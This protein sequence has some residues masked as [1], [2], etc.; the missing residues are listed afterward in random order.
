MTT[1]MRFPPVQGGAGAPTF[2]VGAPPAN[3]YARHN[4]ATIEGR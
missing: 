4:T 3:G 2:P 1:P